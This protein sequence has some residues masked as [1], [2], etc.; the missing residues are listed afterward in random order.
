MNNNSAVC[1]MCNMENETI[2]K[3]FSTSD[4]DNEEDVDSRSNYHSYYVIIGIILILL[5][6]Y[7]IT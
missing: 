6:I 7:L 1:S 3:I 5:L 2:P 4:G